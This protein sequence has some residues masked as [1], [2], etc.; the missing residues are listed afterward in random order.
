[1]GIAGGGAQYKESGKEFTHALACSGSGEEAGSSCTRLLRCASNLS[2]AADSWASTSAPLADLRLLDPRCDDEDDSDLAAKLPARMLAA[3]PASL[4]LPSMSLASIAEISECP[5][6]EV[7]RTA[8]FGSGCHAQEAC[9]PRHIC[10]LRSYKAG[11][12]RKARLLAD[13]TSPLRQ[14][15]ESLTNRV[16]AGAPGGHA[17]GLG[18]GGRL[19]AAGQPAVKAGAAPVHTALLWAAWCKIHRILQPHSHSKFYQAPTDQPSVFANLP[20]SQRWSLQRY[21][22][23]QSPGIT[24]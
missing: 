20:S 17:W 7:A 8:S 12:D 21:D 22:I 6:D 5:L 14:Q 10:A 2:L 15:S 23:T 9:T 24:G 1:M 19:G 4:S 18:H 16:C 3:P 11:I 13:S